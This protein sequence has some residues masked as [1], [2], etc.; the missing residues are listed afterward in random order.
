[1]DELHYFKSSQFIKS[2]ADY[3]DAPSLSLNEV[4]FVGRSNVGKSSLINALTNNSKL[5]YVSSKPGHTRLLNY[6]LIENR[7]YFVDAP[8]YGFSSEKNKDYK[9]Y[10]NM[11]ENYFENN[12]NLRVVIFLL[13][14]RRIPNDDDITIYNYFKENKIPFLI[15]LTKC[16]KINMSEKAKIKVNLSQKFDD[17]NFDSCVLV[18]TT[19]RKLLTNLKNRINEY[20]KDKE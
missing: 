3:K 20:V 14:S 16:D 8:G 5:A 7:F 10:G 4:L 18:S 17:F 11:L 19:Q 15:V 1:M 9:F 2:C 13:D 6:F 12:K